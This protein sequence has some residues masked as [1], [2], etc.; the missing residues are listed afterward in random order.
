MDS[1]DRPADL[2]PLQDRYLELLDRITDTILKGKIRSQEQIYQMLVAGVQLGTG[3]IFER[4]LSDRLNAVQADLDSLKN[5]DQLFQRESPEIKQA[6]WQRSQRALREIEK[7]WERWQQQNRVQGAMATAV[8]QVM[9]APESDRFTALLRAIDP[10]QQQVF[11]LSQ[12]QQLAQALKAAGE[13]GGDEELHREMQA[14]AAGLDRGLVSC[15][16]LEGHLV[17]WIYEASS[18]QQLG[19]GDAASGGRNPWAMWA[20]QVTSPL[21]QLLFATLAKDGSVVEAIASQPNLGLS[22]WVELA[23][24]LQSVQ[25]GLVA[26]FE[27]QPYDSQWGT[28]ASSSTFLA[29]TSIWC[30]LSAGCQQAVAINSTNREVLAKGCFQVALQILRTFAKR[31]YFPLYGG[32]FALFGDNYLRDALNYLDA[33]LRQ[34]EGTQ[35]K[36][37]ILTLLGY[38]QRVVGQYESARSFHQEALEIAQRDGDRPCEIANFNHLSRIEV[39]QKNYDRAINYSQRALIL[40]RQTGDK[41]GEA[42]ALATLGYSEVFLAQQLE[43]MEPEVYERAIAYLQQG[44]NLSER[45]GD[46]QSQVLCSNSLGIAHVV[47]GDPQAALPE[48]KK[49]AKAVQVLGD[50]YLQGLNFTYQAEAYYSLQDQ[51]LAIYYAC[52]GMYIL[53]QIAASEWHQPAGLLTILQGQIGAEAFQQLLAQLRA[54]IIP[55]IGVDGYDHLPELLEERRSG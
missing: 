39:A 32:F 37:R 48:L 51:K 30:Q 23:V 3:E 27:Q 5:P 29:F 21:P 7:Q 44:L 26:W 38:S 47:A 42:N 36:A 50:R 43:R 11:S 46:A 28:A 9:T 52:L 10:N 54:E 40:A 15:Q 22:A 14:L 12:L 55:V 41:L 20:K 34:A 53:E 8:R 33:P 17:R 45:L 16:Q 24:I 35:E 31:S 4:C 1:T 25:G 18:Q 13:S 6:R 49:G 2:P 19:F